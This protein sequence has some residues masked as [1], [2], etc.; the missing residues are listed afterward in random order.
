VDEDVII[1]IDTTEFQA[2]ADE[3]LSGEVISNKR[4]I[5]LKGREF[6]V[7]DKVGLMPLLKFSHA[8]NLRANDDRAYSAM[9]AMLR[10]VIY[11][12]D[13]PCGRCAGCK[14]AAGDPVTRDCETADQGDWSKFEDWATVSKADEDELFDVVT[15]AVKIITARP[16]EL[17]A[18]SSDGSRRTSRSLTAGSSKKRGA[19]SNGSRPGRRAT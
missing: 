18:G 7:A 17:P 15:Q 9:Y 6:R 2:Q 19:A 5:T 8:A 16:T 4:V 10:D 14:S 1:E 12:G 11:E 3:E 13:E